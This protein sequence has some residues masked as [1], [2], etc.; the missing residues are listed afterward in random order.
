MEVYMKSKKRIVWKPQARQ[1]EFMKR[2]EYEVFYGGAAGGG[3]SDALLAEALRQVHIPHYRG[4]IF[5]K[6]V[7]QLSELVDRSREL[8]GA[9]CKGAVFNESKHFWQIGRA[10]V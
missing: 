1:A 10:H 4:L 5:R 7:P 3:K 8:Y 9:V 2:S 6:T